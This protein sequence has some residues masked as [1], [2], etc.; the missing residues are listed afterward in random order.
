M[1]VGYTKYILHIYSYPHIYDAKLMQVYSCHPCEK[2]LLK[3][4]FLVT[5]AKYL[6][7]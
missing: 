2:P 7:R 4:V 1:E 3:W 5:Q 6:F